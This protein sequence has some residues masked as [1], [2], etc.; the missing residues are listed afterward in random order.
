[1]LLR[2]I[3]SGVCIIFFTCLPEHKDF[4][5]N[6]NRFIDSRLYETVKVIYNFQCLKSKDITISSN[7]T[8]AWKCRNS[9]LR[10][11][12]FSGHLA[13][14]MAE[15]SC[16][17]YETILIRTCHSHILSN[18]KTCLNSTDARYI[19]QSK[20]AYASRDKQRI[21]YRQNAFTRH[22]LTPPTKI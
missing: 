10:I 3:D 5:K 18:Y 1:M 4:I 12:F 9:L 8:E 6:Y 17:A 14:H 13:L 16:A 2:Q 11:R 22:L 15:I 21:R 20:I 19:F 7:K